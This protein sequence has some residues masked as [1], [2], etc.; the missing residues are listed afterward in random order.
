MPDPS[1]TCTFCRGDQGDYSTGALMLKIAIIAS[2]S[3]ALVGSAIAADMPTR[4]PPP[5]VA[6]VGKAPV[7]KAPIGKAPIGKGPV[8]ARY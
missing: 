8:V 1:A 6:A 3:L 5:P 4:Q 7:G 2:A